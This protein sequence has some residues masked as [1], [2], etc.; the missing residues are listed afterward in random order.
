MK[1]PNKGEAAISKWLQDFVQKKRANRFPD[2]PVFEFLLF[3]ESNFREIRLHHAAVVV[4]V[5]SCLFF[6]RNV[7]DETLGSEKET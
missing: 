7:C 2:P 1:I 6:L 4:T 5:V 3:E